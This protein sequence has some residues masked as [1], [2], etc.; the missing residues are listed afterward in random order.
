MNA[1]RRLAFASVLAPALALANG[2]D[3]PN[4]G[5]RDSALAGSATAAQVDAAA[6]YANPAALARLGH[7]LHLSLSGSILNLDT[8]WTDTSGAL[9]PASASTKKKPVP[10]VALFAAWGFQAGDRPAAVGI[11]MNVPGGGNVFWEDQWAGRGRIITVDRKIYGAYLTAGYEVMRQLRLGGGLVYYYGTE[12]LRQGI[13]PFPD[14]FGEL[15]TKGG[16]LAFDL[17]AEAAPFDGVPLGLG[18]D[19]KYHGKMKLK[20]DGHFIN[21]PPALAG[22]MLDQG[23]THE[24]TYPSVLNAGVSWQAL[25]ALLLTAGFTYTWYSI[26]QEDLFV[27]SQ[28]L[29][30]RVPRDYGNG[31]TWR[32]GAEW[33][34]LPALQLR[35]G[36]LRDLSG[37]ST[38]AYSPTLPDGDS[39]V[40]SVGAGWKVVPDLTLNA[41]FFRAFLDTVTATGTTALPGR[42][43]TNVW[44]ATLGV[45]WKT[46]V[47]AR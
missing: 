35:A 17:S 6:T 23:V 21:P 29:E 43:Q 34:A 5:A 38:D 41:A 18:V 10:P 12:Y 2:Y 36:V 28:G 7:G 13:Q 26:Y 16:A 37:L 3:V 31:T 40:A 1:L 20:G 30:I 24:L 25:P 45:S 32:L 27:G 44:I 47:G 9:S 42:Y 46:G 33:Q 15:S 22:Q 39:W 11:G 4:T 19:F 14:T 8:R